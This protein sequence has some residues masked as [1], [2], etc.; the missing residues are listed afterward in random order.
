[1]PKMTDQEAREIFQKAIEAQT[2]PDQ[3]AKLEIAR[4]WFTNPDFRKQLSDTVFDL[5]MEA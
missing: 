2:D 1:M 4:E 5:T 3:K